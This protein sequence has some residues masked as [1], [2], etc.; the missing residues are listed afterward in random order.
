M[1]NVLTFFSI[2]NNL[3]IIFILQFSMTFFLSSSPH[4]HH[5][6]GLHERMIY[7]FL[8]INDHHSF[9][10]VVA[11]SFFSIENTWWWSWCWNSNMMIIPLMMI[12]L[13]LWAFF[14]FNSNTINGESFL[15]FCCK[16]R[17]FHKFVF[18]NSTKSDREKNWCDNY[19]VMMYERVF[20]LILQPVKIQKSGKV[21]Q[22][23]YNIIII[24]ILDE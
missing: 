10:S 23:E 12:I 14:S 19:Y 9:F 13:V 22:F 8:S 2:L 6:H 3:I 24:M 17:K 18:L 16:N 21:I 11:V 5:H 1:I 7:H 15:S 20:F 4:H